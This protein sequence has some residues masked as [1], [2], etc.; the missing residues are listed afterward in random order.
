MTLAAFLRPVA[1]ALTIYS[2]YSGAQPTQP[3][4]ATVEVVG[5]V[6][7]KVVHSV[8]SSETTVD[9]KPGPSK[10]TIRAIFEVQD[11][12][13]VKTQ[14]FWGNEPETVVVDK[15]GKRGAFRDFV[16]GDKVSVKGVKS[17]AAWTAQEI[18]LTDKDLAPPS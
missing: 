12:A 10:L 9:G 3:P 2:S 7:A 16:V 18:K 17:G 4:A 11:A 14:F 8:T 13:G 5:T 1:A 6:A 15:S